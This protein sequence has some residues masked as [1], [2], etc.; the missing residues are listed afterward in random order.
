MGVQVNSSD[1]VAH[2][3]WNESLSKWLV[4]GFSLLQWKITDVQVEEAR[5]IHVVMNQS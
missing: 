1:S 2:V 5:M 4:D 3:C